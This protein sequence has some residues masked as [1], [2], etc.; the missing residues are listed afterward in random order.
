MVNKEMKK[1]ESSIIKVMIGVIILVISFFIILTFLR[2]SWN[3][4]ADKETC[5][6][7]VIY[8]SS[9]KVKP[10][11]ASTKAIP[12]KCQTEKICFSMS[13]EDCEI[14]GT[15]DNPVRKIKLNKDVVKAKDE[16][17]E[18]IAESMKECHWMLGEGQLNFMP[19][20][21]T[22]KTYGLICTRFVF[23]KEVKEKIDGISY[24]EIYSYLENKQ[25]KDGRNY[26]EYLHPNWKNAGDAVNIFE[27][28]KREGQGNENF[29][30]EIKNLKFKDWKINTNKEG[31]YAIIAQISPEGNWESYALGGGSAIAIPA[32]AAL[33]ASGIGA[34]VGISL[35]G[36]ATT[37]GVA[38][39]GAVLWYNYPEKY[40]YSPPEIY[41]FDVQSLKIL[42]I[43]SFEIAP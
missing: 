8:R 5:H 31:G 27:T 36:I 34:P 38:T 1:G 10:L 15:K 12:L 17:K 11:E 35:I 30:N 41:P 42:G 18:N 33:I 16:I 2:F 6:Q 28:L 14:A 39:G 9:A 40:D 26:L 7:S 13:G 23:D 32:G 20:K 29:K 21:L 25:L 4:V 24:V 19:H 22:D 3:T 37:T 43:H